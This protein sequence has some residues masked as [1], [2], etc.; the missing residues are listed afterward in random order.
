MFSNQIFALL[1]HNGAG[2]TTTISMIS[3][4]LPISKGS[5]SVFGHDTI[6]EMDKVKTMMGVCP[7]KNPIYSSLTVYEHLY[8]Y[9]KIKGAKGT[10]KE[11]EEQID[12]ILMDIDLLDKKNYFA[13]NLSGG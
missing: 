2:K 5:I 6:S 4:L 12:E 3:G 8:L 9:A 7:Q 1:G 10:R 11:I 13:G